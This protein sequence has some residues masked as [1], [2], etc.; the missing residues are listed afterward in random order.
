MTEVCMN[1]DCLPKS[2]KVLKLLAKAGFRYNPTWD[3]YISP[4]G[5]FAAPMEH[6]YQ[7]PLQI[8]EMLRTNFFKED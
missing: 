3:S 7:E 5:N 1:V 8:A 6:V 2:E 4:C